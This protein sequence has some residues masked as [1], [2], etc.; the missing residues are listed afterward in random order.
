MKAFNRG[1]LADTSYRLPR[2]VS[3][4]KLHQEKWESTEAGR[5]YIFCGN[6]I[7]V[8]IRQLTSVGPG[9]GDVAELI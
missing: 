1:L 9:V 8:I 3:K 7:F 6:L 5:P 4:R 2:G